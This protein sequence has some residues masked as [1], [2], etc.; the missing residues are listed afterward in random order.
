M[1]TGNR[2]ALEA[3]RISIINDFD[4]AWMQRP[5]PW[6]MRARRALQCAKRLAIA[7]DNALM[8][9]V[10]RAEAEMPDTIWIYDTN[11]KR[12]YGRPNY[13]KPG[14]FERVARDAFEAECAANPP[15]SSLGSL[16]RMQ[17]I[18]RFE[19]HLKKGTP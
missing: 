15:R 3:A 14:V 10:I 5:S 12:L 8:L 7:N 6:S 13:D 17:E 19:D 11:G 16:L 2:T 9:P 1:Q 18:N 4:R